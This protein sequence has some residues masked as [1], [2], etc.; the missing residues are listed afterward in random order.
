M[1]YSEAQVLVKNMEQVYA[2]TKLVTKTSEMGLVYTVNKIS[3]ES[4]IDKKYVVGNEVKTMQDYIEENQRRKQEILQKI[5]NQSNYRDVGTWLK[6]DYVSR[7]LETFLWKVNNML[8]YDA[9]SKALQEF[10]NDNLGKTLA[11]ISWNAGNFNLFEIS[12][13]RGIQ[14]LLEST[15]H[16]KE[17]F[18][19]VQ[20]SENDRNKLSN[21]FDYIVTTLKSTD[22]YVAS[23][24][25]KNIE[26]D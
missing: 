8:E 13:F 10:I 20:W 17:Y 15:S 2:N 16:L 22:I 5:E 3:Y 21:L 9:T 4:Y 7:D 18:E 1:Y 19:Q 23:Q 6:L 24:S 11:N 14:L 25:T 12:S 26:E